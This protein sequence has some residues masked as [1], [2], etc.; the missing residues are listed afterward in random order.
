MEFKL[1][2]WVSNG[3]DGSANVMFE[4]TLSRAKKKCDE[5]DEGWGE[6]SAGEVRLK[7]E[8]G[9]LFAWV[10]IPDPEDDD[11]EIRGWV[12]VPQA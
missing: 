6:S 12:K 4:S 9:K 10:W 7:V 8:E 1:P 3:G 5:Q 2:Y 11:Q